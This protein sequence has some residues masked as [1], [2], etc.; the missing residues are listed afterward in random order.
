MGFIL[1]KELKYYFKRPL[2]YIGIVL[3]ILYVFSNVRPY[4]NIQYYDKDKDFVEQSYKKTEDVE[5]YEGYIPTTK[6][7]KFEKGIDNIYNELVNQMMV[8]EEVAKKAVE[9]IRNQSM[10][11]EQIR[12]YMSQ[13]FNIHNIQPYFVRGNN[14]KLASVDEVNEYIKERLSV[15]RFSQYLGRKFADYM[16]VAIVFFSMVMLVFLCAKDFERD[17]YELLHTKPIKSYQFII[18]KILGGIIAVGIAIVII[19]AIFDIILMMH[20]NHNNLPGN[21][22]DLWFYILICNMPVVVFIASLY[23]FITGIFK[24]SLPT[25]PII[26]LFVIYS[27]IGKTLKNGNYEYVQ[28]PLSIL[29]RFPNYFFETSFNNSMWVSQGLLI[30]ITVLLGGCSIYMWSRR[31]L[32]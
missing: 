19:T 12:E 25:I 2:Y 13:N 30:I 24:T 27:N 21:W 6:E 1:R 22:F 10:N 16:S 17:M 8:D 29:T 20:C 3:V 23:I 15:E 32:I 31:R 11:M 9:T 26:V 14:Y 7:E 5:I 4:L 18:G 28:K